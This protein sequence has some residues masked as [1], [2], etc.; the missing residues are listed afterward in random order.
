MVGGGKGGNRVKQK[1]NGKNKHLASQ[2]QPAIDCNMIQIPTDISEQDLS[3]FLTT[4][5][6]YYYN[7]NSN[8][9]NGGR[10]EVPFADTSSYT[11]STVNNSSHTNS[12]AVSPTSCKETAIQSGPI[13]PPASLLEPMSLNASP[14]Q[15]QPQPQPHHGVHFANSVQVFGSGGADVL[16][17]RRN[18]TRRLEPGGATVAAVLW[19]W[20]AVAAHA[21]GVACVVGVGVAQP[22]LDAGALG[23]VGAWLAVQG[24]AVAWCASAMSAARHRHLSARKEE[25]EA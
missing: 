6:Y 21:V 12:T 19:L 1:S 24:L 4:S 14:T 10:N 22:H 7:A 16:V 13:S 3:S 9:S 20:A 15:P 2:Q 5:S 11:S 25:S 18:K 8:N 23:V 17:P